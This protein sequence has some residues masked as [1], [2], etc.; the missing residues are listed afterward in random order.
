MH[1]SRAEDNVKAFNGRKNLRCFRISY[2]LAT[3]PQKENGNMRYRAPTRMSCRY[4]KKKDSLA[5]GCCYPS[6]TAV[7]LRDAGALGTNIL[8]HPGE[9]SVRKRSTCRQAYDGRSGRFFKGRDSC[10]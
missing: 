4:L 3:A 8:S 5:I 9:S 6:L 10:P 1:A 7:V 2:A